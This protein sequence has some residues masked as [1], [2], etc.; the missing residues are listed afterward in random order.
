MLFDQSLLQALSEA[1]T[2]EKGIRYFL[3]GHVKEVSASKL[4]NGKVKIDGTVIGTRDYKPSLTLSKG[5]D[6]IDFFDCDCPYAA[7]EACKHVIALGM[8]ALPLEVGDVEAKP[9]QMMDMI[10][11]L[12]K[13]RKVEVSEEEAERL[14]KR[15]TELGVHVGDV[16]PAERRQG[17]RAKR[18]ERHLLDAIVV[19]LGYDAASDI[20]SIDVFARYGSREMPLLSGGRP[21]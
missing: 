6:A 2:H 15:L 5:L 20:A 19:K 11:T 13:K 14:S 4:P 9:D 12:A 18:T 1:D 7:R 16:S 21:L 3:D 8:A 17:P 10:K